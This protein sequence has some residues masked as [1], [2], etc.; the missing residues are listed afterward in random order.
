MDIIA[1]VSW[2]T[3][4]KVKTSIGN[5]ISCVFGFVCL[6]MCKS[7]IKCNLKNEKDLKVELKKEK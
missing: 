4:Y 6:P 2:R 1:F 3:D 5:L 7:C